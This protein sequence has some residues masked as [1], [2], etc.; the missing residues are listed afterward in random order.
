MSWYELLGRT[1]NGGAI[2][3]HT[4]NGLV[5]DDLIYLGPE[6]FKTAPVRETDNKTLIGL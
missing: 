2:V 5:A 1:R 6:R 3:G 4:Q